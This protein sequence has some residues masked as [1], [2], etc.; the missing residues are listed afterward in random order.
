MMAFS[1]DDAKATKAVI[2]AGMI[3]SCMNIAAPVLLAQ[4]LYRHKDAEMMVLVT[5]FQ[6]VK[7]SQ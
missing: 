2:S 6:M 1:S 3:R 7:T 5:L 4:S